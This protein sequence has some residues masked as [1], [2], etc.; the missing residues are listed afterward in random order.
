MFNYGTMA[1]GGFTIVD[2]AGAPATSQVIELRSLNGTA[3]PPP[4]LRLAIA[5]VR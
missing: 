4:T 3:D 2:L 1:G 5:R